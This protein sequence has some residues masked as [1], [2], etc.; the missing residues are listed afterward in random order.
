VLLEDVEAWV[1]RDVK[2]DEEEFEV[3]VSLLKRREMAGTRHVLES[4]S[5]STS[6]VASPS[7]CPGCS[8][9][10]WS[11]WD[12]DSGFRLSKLATRDSKQ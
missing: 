7:S 4:S 9:Q 3:G 5:S 6:V 12:R 10:S 2:L 1:E 8:V 11:I